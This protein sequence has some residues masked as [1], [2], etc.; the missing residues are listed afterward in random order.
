MAYII[1]LAGGCLSGVMGGLFLLKNFFSVV[2]L[3]FREKALSLHPEKIEI[4]VNELLNNYFCP[5][6]VH[7]CFLAFP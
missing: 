6:F 5:H 4:V 2:I 7:T 3:F 1:S